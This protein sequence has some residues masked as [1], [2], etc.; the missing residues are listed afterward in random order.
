MCL[1]QQF[2]IRLRTNTIVKIQRDSKNTESTINVGLVL[3]VFVNFGQT[4]TL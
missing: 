4:F 2:H 1:V 3:R